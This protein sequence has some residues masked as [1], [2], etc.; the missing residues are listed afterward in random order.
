MTIR[1]NVG[2]FLLHFTATEGHLP[3]GIT[4]CYLPPDVASLSLIQT[5]VVCNSVPP[6][7]LSSPAISRQQCRAGLKTQ[8]FKETYTVSNSENIKL[9]TELN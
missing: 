7:P 1:L 4:Q 2:D 8:L 6:H 9:S 3:Y 5:P